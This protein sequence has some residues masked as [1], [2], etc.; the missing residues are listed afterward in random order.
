MEK[1]LLYAALINNKKL[2]ELQDQGDFTTLFV[3]T[4]ALKDRPYGLV[5]EEYLKEQGLELDY[6]TPI[7]EYEKQVLSKRK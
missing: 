4:E 2:K 7:R 3:E 5:W 6:L 1:A